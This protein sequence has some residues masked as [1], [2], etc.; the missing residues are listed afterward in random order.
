M[1]EWNLKIIVYCWGKFEEG[2][3]VVVPAL[4][5][6]MLPWPIDFVNAQADREG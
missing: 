3:N 1:Q 6:G 4:D 5:W 2:I